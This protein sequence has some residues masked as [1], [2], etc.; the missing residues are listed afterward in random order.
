MIARDVRIETDYGVQPVDVI[1]DPLG[2]GSLLCV[3][4]DTGPFRPMT[5]ANCTTWNRATIISRRWR[6]S[7]A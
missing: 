5:A 1:C 4:R 7:C 6:T 3:F 2:D